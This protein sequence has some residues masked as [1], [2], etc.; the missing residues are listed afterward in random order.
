MRKII[1][2]NCISKTTNDSLTWR[3]QSLKQAVAIQVLPDETGEPNYGQVHETAW[4][5]PARQD[6]EGSEELLGYNVC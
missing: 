2:L 6:H 5:S 1:K 3:H 4:E